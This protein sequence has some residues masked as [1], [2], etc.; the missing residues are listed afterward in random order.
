LPALALLPSDAGVDA[1]LVSEHAD[2]GRETVL[3]RT[4]VPTGGQAALFV[5]ERV[6]GAAGYVLAL[7]WLG[8]ADPDAVAAARQQ[9][10]G[11][12]DADEQSAQ[13]AAF[14][15][16]ATAVGADNR[17]PALLALLA[18]RG[19]QRVVDLVLAADEPALIALS[20]SLSTVDPTLPDAWQLER[21]A[22]R[23]LLPRIE[24]EELTAALFAATTRHLGAVAGQGATLDLLLS[25]S[26]DDDAF[27]RALCDENIA[28]LDDRNTALRVTAWDWLSAHGVDLPGYDPLAERDVRR[29]A[30]RRYWSS[31]PAQ[32]PR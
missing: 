15:V 12:R 27:A 6:A 30:V 2:T 7:R 31:T 1:V 24:R 5:P 29:R 20:A 32:E 10:P 26:A 9:V 18:P 13:P 22:W 11:A 19:V 28:A 14:R 4:A 21:G 3:F 17:R 8:A 23:A 16:A 25:T